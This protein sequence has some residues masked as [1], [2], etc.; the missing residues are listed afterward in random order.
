MFHVTSPEHF[1]YVS[2][3]LIGVHLTHLLPLSPKKLRLNQ[4]S[5]FFHKNITN[6]KM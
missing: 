6:T 4:I 1:I 3:I 2:L 5:H